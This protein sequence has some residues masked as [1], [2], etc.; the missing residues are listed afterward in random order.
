MNSIFDVADEA[1]P[2]E[3]KFKLDLNAEL[4][5]V[6]TEREQFALDLREEVSQ[7]LVWVRFVQAHFDE[8]G[9]SRKACTATLEVIAARL[10]NLAR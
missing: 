3:V 2:E 4:L 9:A 5:R 1:D 10:Q 8:G 6:Q 7:L